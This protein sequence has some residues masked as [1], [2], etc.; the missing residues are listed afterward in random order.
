VAGKIVA[1]CKD[2][3]QATAVDS[4]WNLYAVVRYLGVVGIGQGSLRPLH[5]CMEQP[6]KD[7]QFGAHAGLPAE[8]DEAIGD[9]QSAR[10][11]PTPVEFV[12]QL[13]RVIAYYLGLAVVAHVIVAIVGR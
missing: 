4:T 2:R 7:V 3:Y 10:T 5:Y 11:Y 6:V 12:R 1:A 9:E 8:S 13:S